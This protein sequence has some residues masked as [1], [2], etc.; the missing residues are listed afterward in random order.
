M[1][2]NG[3]T[4]CNSAAPL[5]FLANGILQDRVDA[6]LADGD[7]LRAKYRRFEGG[8]DAGVQL[9]NYGELRIG[10]AWGRTKIYELNGLS[11]TDDQRRINQAGA[12]VRLT[13][14]QFDNVDFPRSGFLG[15][16]ELYSSREELGADL[17]YNRLS[18]GWNHAFSFG[19]NAILGG[20]QF[21]GKIGE[22]LPFYEN[23]AV[24]GFLNLSGFPFEGLADQYGG[25]GRLVFYRRVLHIGRG[26]L[27]AIY[28]GG[29][30]ETGGVWRHFDEIDAEGLIFAGSIFVGADTLFGPL[31]LAYGQS[32][33]GRNAFYF[34]LGRNF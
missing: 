27:S 9:A 16:L 12:R 15:G 8:V 20:F 10:P 23:L 31:Y 11:L 14:D 25:V 32:E 19:E 21:G 2:R 3:R 28:L 6:E 17:N 33:E 24:G 29:S 26:A 30:A 1:A 18:V 34:Y 22:D 4:R 7:L 5:A 13:L